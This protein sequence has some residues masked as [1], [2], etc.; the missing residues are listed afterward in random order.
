[1]KPLPV[2][3]GFGGI[4]AAGLSSAHHGYRRTVIDALDPGLA[5]GT[6]R[7]LAGLMRIEGEI[8]RLEA[9]LAETRCDR[10]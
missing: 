4:N 1:M 6:I 2:I 10:L 5:D 7:A 8:E 9:Q 3:A